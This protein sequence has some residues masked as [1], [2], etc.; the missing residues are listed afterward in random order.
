MS[1]TYYL[2]SGEK[3]ILAMQHFVAEGGEGRVFVQDHWAYKIAHDPQKV[4]PAAKLR[5]LSVLDHPL[6]L[7]P[8]ALVYDAQRQARGFRMPYVADTLALPRLFTHDFRQQRALDNTQILQLLAQMQHT[9]QFIHQQQCLL[10]DGNEINYLVSQDCHIPYF[11]DVDSYQTPNFPATALMPSIQDYHSQGFST[12]TDWFA[13]A[14]VACQLLLGIH[15]YKGK[16]PTLKT[17]AE[18]MQANISIFNRSVSLPACVRDFGV[19]PPAWRDWFI[20]LFEQGQRCPPPAL[21]SYFSV[22]LP[23]LNLPLQAQRFHMQLL[24]T[25][26]AAIR[27]HQQLHGKTWVIAGAQVFT[28]QGIWQLPDP[29]APVLYEP[30]H[31]IF[32]AAVLI[33]GRLQLVNLA[34]QEVLPTQLSAQHLL[35]VENQ[36]Y[37]IQQDQLIA[38]N[39]T[40]LGQKLLISAG[41]SWQILPKAH[42]V[43]DGMLTQTVLGQTYVIIPYQ[44]TACLIKAI[45]ELKAYTLLSGKYQNGVVMLLGYQHGR[46][47]LIMLCFDLHYQNYQVRI[48]PDRD[49]A[50]LNFTTLENGTVLAIFQDGELEVSHR[51]LPSIKTITD[52]HISSLMRLSHAEN[53]GLFY[54]DSQLYQISLKTP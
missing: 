27:R 7:R 35:Q 24:K 31:S 49:M 8:H 4:L 13:F 50:E 2:G 34:T 44:A 53:M 1:E 21:P 16:H 5:E 51:H 52:P 47:D 23:V 54:T 22:T 37:A 9:V 6:I 3:I 29:T 12:L 45:P 36:L 46:Y 20:A 17:L 11:I 33:Q 38:V 43:F 48:I 32:L 10:V 28:D 39:I 30:L 41:R 25:Y 19:I 15:P 18:R 40:R 42:Q 14:V 26:T